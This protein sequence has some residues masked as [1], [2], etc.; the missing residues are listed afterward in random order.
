MA[1]ERIA[2]VTGAG[3]SAASGIST[4]RG[5]D[6]E[7]VWNQNDIEMATFGFFQRDPVTQWQWYLERFRKA[8]AAQP[9]DAHRA[10]VD[11][12]GWMSESGGRLALV[13]Q[14]ID[15]LHEQAIAERR[16]GGALDL[17]KVHGSADRVRCARD[18][19]RLGSPAGSILRTEVDFSGF[20]ESPDRANLPTCPDC[21][22]WLRAH[23]LF[24]D[25][26][27]T[28]HRDYRY[29]DVVEV[30]D[31]A[32]FLLFIGTSL[33]VGV[34]EMFQQQ[35]ALRGI[36]VYSIDPAAAPSPY[37]HIQILPA[38]AE[39]LLPK[40]VKALTEAH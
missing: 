28:E 32:K 2:V 27:Y 21:G 7:A 8:T 15:T 13:T 20:Q 19:C 29:R 6:P 22:S 26:Y 33:S 3:I 17:I 38:P 31:S 5:S 40:V 4:F 37:R 35:A 1:S 25:E 39:E 18:G 11:L 14:N 24:F 16:G 30:A 23:V 9:N 34:T 36:P 10:L 12:A